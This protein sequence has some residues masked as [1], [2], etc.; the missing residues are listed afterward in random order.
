MAWT[1]TYKEKREEKQLRAEF[2]AKYGAQK[3]SPSFFAQKT[4]A[5][6]RAWW[7]SLTLEQQQAYIEKRQAQKNEQRQGQSSCPVFPEINEINESN[8]AE[9]QARIKKLN[10]WVQFPASIKQEIRQTA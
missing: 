8:R 4:K 7:A 3:K 9:W 6:R 1:M 2:K 10:P 5:S